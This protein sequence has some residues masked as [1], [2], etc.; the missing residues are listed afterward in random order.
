MRKHAP[1]PPARQVFTDPVHFLAFGFGL[2]LSPKAPGTV[3]TL[4]ALPFLLLSAQWHFMAQL[5][6][7]VAVCLVGIW[8]CGESARRLDSHDHPGI[9]WDEIGGWLVTMLLVPINPLTLVAGYLL[10]RFFD[11]VKPWPIR[12]LDR[13]VHGGLGI[14]LDDI[15]AAVMAGLV[16]WIGYSWHVGDFTHAML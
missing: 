14:M 7:A 2:G 3:G 1:M 6:L 9:V 12:W 11:I 4:A 10:F 13:H 15:I 5:A 16:L 8:I